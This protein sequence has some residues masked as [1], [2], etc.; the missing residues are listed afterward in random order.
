MNVDNSANVDNGRWAA[1]HSRQE[2]E[3]ATMTESGETE[4]SDACVGRHG[5]STEP[6][7]AGSGRHL[8]KRAPEIES[9]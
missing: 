1:F 6:C 7:G 3:V 4:T 8:E 5:E 2:A 9:R